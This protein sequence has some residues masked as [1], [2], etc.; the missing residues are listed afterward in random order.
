MNEREDQPTPDDSGFKSILATTGFVI[1]VAGILLFFGSGVL[2]RIG[3]ALIE[4]TH[5][6]VYG[7]Y[8][9]WPIATMIAGLLLITT[10]H[11]IK[12]MLRATS[13]TEPRRGRTLL[14][15]SRP[16]RQGTERRGSIE[17]RYS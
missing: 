1:G 12:G 3:K 9:Q 6:L 13:R 15:R 14:D 16:G 7:G 4:P 5:R 8:T 17:R 2:P 11:A 10:A